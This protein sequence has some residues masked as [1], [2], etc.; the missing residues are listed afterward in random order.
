MGYRKKVR[1]EV[2]SELTDHF[3]D[4][5]SDCKTDEE[6]DTLVQT[7]I[8]QFGDPKLLA[9]LIRRAKKRCRPLWKKAIIRSFQ[10]TAILLLLIVARGLTLN[11]GTATISTDYVQWLTDLGKQNRDDSLNAK[12][13]YDKAIEL[14][15][16]WSDP[17]EYLRKPWPDQW[18]PR[19]IITVRNILKNNAEALEWLRKGAHKPYYWRV[20]GQPP[21]DDD[22]QEKLKPA[23]QRLSGE[24]G[25]AFMNEI[26]PDIMDGM[27]SYRSLARILNLE[28]KM[29]ASLGNLNKAV[30]DGMVLQ[31]FG[32]HL[33]G[34]GALIEQLVGVA[35]D[36]LAIKNNF[37]LLKILDV[38]DD[39]LKNTQLELER[40]YDQNNRS[41]NFEAEK[42]FMLDA[43]QR[44]FT[45][46]G[47]GNGRMLME[48]I[49][50]TIGDNKGLLK[51]FFLGFPDRREVLAMIESFYQYYQNKSER[52]PWQ[53]HSQPSEYNNGDS[54]IKPNLTLQVLGPALIHSGQNAW[55]VKASRDALLTVIALKRWKLQEGEV[56]ESLTELVDAGFLERLPL[57]PYSDGPLTYKKQGDDFILY[58]YAGDF[59]DDQG[60]QN[61]DRPWAD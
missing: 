25:N 21:L 43:V 61:A 22:P 7:L 45:D 20:Y 39:I 52:T 38:P 6:K 50:L 54:N 57:D 8:E 30:T 41:I 59:D 17:N 3:T 48:G 47:K 40:L 9:Q 36:M 28:I 58:S 34:K 51:G 56:P 14:H 23:S 33:Q 19:Q 26:M 15:T 49:P 1:E 53:L 42:T 55:K 29:N 18:S 13:F 60:R 46:D 35:I 44:S 24:Y 10:G 4:A 27:S 12:P 5:T 16:P 37:Q 32:M 2:K 11:I 31:K